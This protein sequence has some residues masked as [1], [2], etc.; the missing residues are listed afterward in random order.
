MAQPM[1][2]R[3][4]AG[5]PSAI[6]VIQSAET[7]ATLFSPARMQVL[8]SLAEPDSAAGVARRL[9]L[10]RQQVAYHLRE[11]ERARLVD[12]V[13]ERRRGNCLE[14]VMRASARSYVIGPEALGK[15]GETPHQHSDLFSISYLVGLAMRAVRDLAILCARAA[16][17]GKR[18]VT[19]GLEVE[20]RFASAGARAQFAEEL[21][22]EIARLA[23]K[24]DDEAAPGGRR[25]RL[26]AGVYP[27]MNRE[28]PA[29]TASVR[30]Q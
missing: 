23:A 19:L 25:C 10:P 3:S 26:I 8:E 24:Y 7:A 28:E 2:A 20:V 13:E 18:V 16:R 15:L 14:R 11:L 6:H 9:N 30:M 5:M 17:A 29:G 21:R 1:A 27:V 22:R 12:L 4:G